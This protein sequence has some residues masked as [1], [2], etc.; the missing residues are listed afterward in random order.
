VLRIVG[1]ELTDASGLAFRLNNVAD[2]TITV[3]SL[4]IDP[5]GEGAT[6]TISIAAAAPVGARV[7]QVL[8]PASVST[9]IGTTGN[10]F[11]VQ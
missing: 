9:A 10:R 2:N 7:L 5:D 11:T 1:A 6:A 3:T 4:V 8:T